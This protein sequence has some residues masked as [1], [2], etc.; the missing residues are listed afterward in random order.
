MASAWQGVQRAI[1]RRSPARH[2]V[3]GYAR[4][5]V[6]SIRK[7]SAAASQFVDALRAD[8]AA[9]QEFHEKYGR[10]G[11]A[12]SPL[13][14]DVVEK[15]GLQVM[16]AY[17]LMRFFA[18]VDARLASRITSRMIR[19]LYGSD[20]HWEADI[21]PGV[22]VVHGMGMAISHSARVGRSVLL[23]QHC[24]LGEGRHPDTKEVG[25]PNVEDGA[26]VGAGAVVVGPITIGARSKIMPGCV[27]VR[28]VPP[29]CL[30]ESPQ[31]I[32]RPRRSEQNGRRSAGDRE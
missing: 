22:M 20:I 1:E 7:L 6:P 31:A 3:L 26:V 4:R 25:A 14:K 30:V 24:T 29:D 27:V 5:T 19:H 28:S 17:R 2:C 13:A 9:V 11:G 18:A 10:S 15:I 21:A 23:F 32:V 12:S 8:H 16:A